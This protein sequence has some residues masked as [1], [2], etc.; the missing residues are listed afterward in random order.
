MSARSQKV[1]VLGVAGRSGSGKTTLIERLLPLLKGQGLR[2]AVIKHTH[3]DLEFDVPGKDSYR[4]K[5]AG[6]VTS[7][8]V[9]PTGLGIVKDFREE[10]SLEEII[11]RYATDCD[12]IIVEGFK[13]E[14]APKIEVFS[15][16]RG[17]PPLCLSGDETYIAIVTDED[18]DTPLPRF[19][20]DDITAIA[21]FVTTRVL[22]RDIS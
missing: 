18:I 4:F 15:A 13:H 20:R 16:D 22:G 2:V 9:S 8:L 6:A 1:F 12:M 14:R 7:V 17:E 21:R 3:H 10:P 11:S 19:T 5:Q